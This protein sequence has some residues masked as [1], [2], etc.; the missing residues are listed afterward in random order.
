MYIH[1][2]ACLYMYLYTFVSKTP[3][4]THRRPPTRPE[5]VPKYTKQFP[6]ITTKATNTYVPGRSGSDLWEI[7]KKRFALAIVGG[8]VSPLWSTLRASQQGVSFFDV[9]V[10][11]Y[12]FL[13][14]SNDFQGFRIDSHIHCKVSNVPYSILL[15]MIILQ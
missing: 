13:M 15:T 7:F 12:R 3:T 10:K 6:K 8:K 1:A 11:T 5:N 9:P 14:V 4:A 2:Y